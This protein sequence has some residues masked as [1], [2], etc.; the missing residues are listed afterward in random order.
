MKAV[1]WINVIAILQFGYLLF[2]DSL[3]VDLDVRMRFTE[4]DRAGVIN[5]EALKDCHGSY[6]FSDIRNGV[7]RYVAEPALKAQRQAAA[8]GLVLAVVNAFLAGFWLWRKARSVAREKAP[9]PAYPS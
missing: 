9:V 5:A 7:P 3:M 6:G 4:L 2:V 1:L 8:T